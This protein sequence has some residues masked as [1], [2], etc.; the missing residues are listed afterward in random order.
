[1]TAASAPRPVDR[2]PGVL[3]RHEAAD[4]AL[5]RVRLPGGIVGAQGL[6]VIAQAA[7]LG[8]GVIELTARASIQIRGLRQA[9][10][11][12]CAALLA[13]GGLLPSSAHDRARNI[14]ASPFGG[15]HPGAVAR[16]D[17]LVRALD[18]ALC[19]EAQLA[20]LPGRFLFAVDD[21]TR[22]SGGERAD[23][24]LLAD[25]AEQFSLALRGR[26][27]GE[28]AGAT[29]AVA[30]AL[31][32][33]RRL[34]G[35]PPT[36]SRSAD[37]QPRRISL[38]ALRQN[39]GRAALTVMPRLGRLDVQTAG[40]LAALLDAHGTDARISAARTITLVDL[41]PGELSG[42]RARLRELGLIDDDSSP[43]RGLSAC[44]GLGH[45]HRAL[46]DVRALAQRRA[47]QRTPLSPPEHWAGCE[48]RCGHP[49]G[50]HLAYTATPEGIKAEWV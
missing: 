27:T 42:V 4:G 10:G 28:V 1:M 23:V 8:S 15:R 7:A 19:A 24:A 29:R 47:A 32:A 41:D 12:R 9:D 49:P 48:R 36:A 25:G 35:E 16:T 11:E 5:A 30:L 44:A 3:S 40:A 14:L 43:W 38:G 18:R 2:C 33:A 26:I 31:R 6:G 20:G 13:A 17:E 50:S 21:G 45:C 22:L 34:L 39:D 37:R 46:A